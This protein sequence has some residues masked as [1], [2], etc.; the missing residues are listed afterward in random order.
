MGVFYVESPSMRLLQKKSGR[1]DFE[2]LVIHSSIIRP[3]AN[4]FIQEYLRRLH[5][6]P[7]EP[8]HPKLKDVLAENYGILVYQEDVVQA[9]MILAGF[10]WGEADS[11]RKV[12]S[13]KSRE[14]LSNYK[15]RFAEGCAGNGIS[16]DLIEKV[17]EMFTS[18][19]GYSFCKPHSASYALVSFKS[20]HLKVHYPAEFMAAV[21]SN[22]GG[23]YS[24]FAYISEARRMGLTVAGPDVNESRF[25][26]T[27]KGKII[28]TGFQQI[29]NL[30]K[31]TVDAIPE[32]REQNGPFLSLEDFLERVPVV[33]SDASVLA[34]SGAL[35]SISG[36]FS[37][38]QV[39]WFMEAWLNK[40]A[41]SAPFSNG[42]T[43]MRGKEQKMRKPEGFPTGRTRRSKRSRHKG[44]PSIHALRYG[45][46]PF[47][48]LRSGKN[49]IMNGRPSALSFRR[50]LSISSRRFSDLPDSPSFRLPILRR[51]SGK[52]S[53]QRAGPSPA[54]R[55]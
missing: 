38:P 16:S 18:F 45:S 53:G 27:G 36:G 23:Y 22:G 55:C 10:T 33:L 39:L 28:R 25:H 19:S 24:T 30:K 8:L 3:A 14:Q 15:I 7:Y 40:F 6:E 42:G 44:P 51:T 1:G 17:W 43:G 35:D 50:I 29:R 13:K 34:R 41:H 26:Y 46:L 47:P 21:L 52:R 31:S 54:K 4:R 12:I 11:L 32:E 2:H 48:I 49:G 20:A 9:A 5:G 37:R